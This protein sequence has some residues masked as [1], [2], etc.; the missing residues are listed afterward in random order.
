MNH[1]LAPLRMTFSDDGSPA[2]DAAWEWVIAQ[3][4]PGWRVDVLQSRLADVAHRESERPRRAP[5]RCGFRSVRTLTSTLEPRVAAA[6]HQGSD[7]IV[8]GDDAGH[9]LRGSTAGQ[10]IAWLSRH[11]SVPLLVARRP[12]AVRSVLACVGGSTDVGPGVDTLVSLPWVEQAQVVVLTV[13]GLGGDAP[14]AAHRAAQVLMAAGVRAR[15]RVVQPDQVIATSS[16]TYRIL[17]TIDR[18]QPDVV[19]V[20][21]DAARIGH[22]VRGSVAREVLRHAPCSVLLAGR[23]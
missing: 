18:L 7:L 15:V 5:R 3:T 19:V 6:S 10:V 16:P 23:R 8:L 2:A 20:G 11:S 21:N 9:A 17:Q 4:W 13:V 12:G 14:A 22:A 1:R